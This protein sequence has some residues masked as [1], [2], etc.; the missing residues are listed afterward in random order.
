[1]TVIF[2]KANANYSKKNIENILLNSDIPAIRTWTSHEQHVLMGNIKLG[3]TG[4]YV[5]NVT[6]LKNGETVID[7][8]ILEVCYR[9][10]STTKNK[11]GKYSIGS[12]KKPQP[13]NGIPDI[14]NMTGFWE[15]VQKS[16]KK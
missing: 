14:T 12:C 6:I 7:K 2:S 16:Y 1:M 11:K 10:Y 3:S 4:K 8:F 15:E 5:L 9:E 13:K